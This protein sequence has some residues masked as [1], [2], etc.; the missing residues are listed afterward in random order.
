MPNDATLLL[1]NRDDVEQLLT[2]DDVLAAMQRAF[3]LHSEAKGRVFPVVREPLATGGL[4]GIKSGD[5]VALLPTRKGAPSECGFSQCGA[6][7]DGSA[8]VAQSSIYK[9]Y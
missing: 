2:V 8:A 7:C 1:L 5:V 9:M 3:V 4:F 6:R